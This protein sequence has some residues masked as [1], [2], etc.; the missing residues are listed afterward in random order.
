M[1]SIIMCLTSAQKIMVILASATSYTLGEH[2]H[3]HSLT[4]VVAVH[5]CMEVDEGFHPGP[6]DTFAGRFK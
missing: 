4:R 2:V 6:L 5:A 3:W 1:K